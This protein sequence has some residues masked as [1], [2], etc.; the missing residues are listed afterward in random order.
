MNPGGPKQGHISTNLI[1]IVIKTIL[2]GSIDLFLII[3][4][5]QDFFYP[6]YDILYKIQGHFH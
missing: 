2:T 1:F 4:G 3:K 5:I 6:A